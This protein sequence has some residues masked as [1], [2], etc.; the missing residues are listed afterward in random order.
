[1][2]NAKRVYILIGLNSRRTGL[3]LVH[4]VA[5]RIE[6]FIRCRFVMTTWSTLNLHSRSKTS[7]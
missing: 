4:K 6:I 7:E 2:G 3:Y 1:M 5:A